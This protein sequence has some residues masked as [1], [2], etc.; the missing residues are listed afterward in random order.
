[1]SNLE[2][3]IQVF[4]IQKSQGFYSFGHMGE[5]QILNS[6]N[7][8]N[9]SEIFKAKQKEDDISENS[10]NFY[11]AIKVCKKCDL[12][13]NNSNQ[14]PPKRLLFNEICE[15]NINNKVRAIGNPNLVQMYDW[16]IDRKTTEVRILME[17]MPYDLRNYFSKK[18]N[19]LQLNENLLK[20]FTF[21]ILNG[22]N[23]LHKNRII[24]FD[25]K[26]ENI[27]YNPENNSIKI[28][29]FSVSQI[30]TYD[31]DKKILING[32]TYSYQPIESLMQT[33]DISFNCD[34]WSL[35][36]ILLELS[37][38]INPFKG[39][40]PNKVINNIISVLGMDKA[41]LTNFDEYPKNSLNNKGIIDFI[42]N[43]HKIKFINEDFHDLVAKMLHI[44]PMERITAEEALNHPWLVGHV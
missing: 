8:G 2:N 5:F 12:S 31:L 26:P 43:N 40:S 14:N 21:Q 32:G 10:K 29:D 34:M 27:L 23:A 7:H 11:Y 17:Y 38:R 15:I 41:S 33:K 1:M 20:N 42:K 18:E 44:N 35:G 22:L 16:S 30:V 4:P 25:L 28:A 13:Q 9:L 24:H 39:N 36:C 37:C 6:I 19:Y 3:R